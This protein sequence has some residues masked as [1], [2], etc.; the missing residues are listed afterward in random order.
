[1][2]E[3]VTRGQNR[4]L[5]VAQKVINSNFRDVWSVNRGGKLRVARDQTFVDRQ[6]TMVINDDINSRI[7]LA[8]YAIRF[9]VCYDRGEDWWESNGGRKNCIIR[10][11][12]LSAADKRIKWIFHK[13]NTF[14]LFCFQSRILGLVVFPW[15]QEIRS[16]LLLLQAATAAQGCA[17][18][19]YFNEYIKILSSH[20]FLLFHCRSFRFDSAPI[21]S[22]HSLQLHPRRQRTKEPTDNDGDF[23][24]LCACSFESQNQFFQ[25]FSENR[26]IMRMY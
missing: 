10:H 8:K 23:S 12:W 21:F 26:W 16:R 22:L 4:N 5:S 15:L 24:S 20:T 7:Y 2:D 1:M 19:R 3:S 11:V 25:P 17:E 9:I 6:P 18:L 14:F 13:Y